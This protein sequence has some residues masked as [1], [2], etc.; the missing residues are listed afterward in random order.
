VKENELIVKCICG[1]YLRVLEARLRAGQATCPKC[2]HVLDP[3]HVETSE[4]SAADTQTI[5]IQEMARMAQEGIELE[6][7]GEWN[8]AEPQQET[9]KD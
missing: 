8:T 2:K 9:K 7:S 5:N 6:I 3:L 4:V 1:A